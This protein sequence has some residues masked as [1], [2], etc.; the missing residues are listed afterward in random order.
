MTMTITPGY[1]FEEESYSTLSEW[2]CNYYDFSIVSG[3][4]FDEQN[5]DRS[6]CVLLPIQPSNEYYAQMKIDIFNLVKTGNFEIREIMN[7]ADEFWL[8]KDVADKTFILIQPGRPVP[9]AIFKRF[10]LVYPLLS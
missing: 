9:A 5:K 1:V 10:K 2:M 8:D 3:G 7:D 4:D 6:S